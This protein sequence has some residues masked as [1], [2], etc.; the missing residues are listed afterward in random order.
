MARGFIVELC[1]E[2]VTSPDL[3]NSVLPHIQPIM[4]LGLKFRGSLW[5]ILLQR[6][7]QTF[8]PLYAYLA[9]PPP[10]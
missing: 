2:L 5:A 3:S 8:C 7:L 10:K 4:L 9:N 6:L 1:K